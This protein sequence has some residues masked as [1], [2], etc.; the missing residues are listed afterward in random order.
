MYLNII[1]FLLPFINYLSFQATMN[2]TQ[3]HSNDV[4]ALKVIY[5]SM[6]LVCKVFF[7]LNY[8][9][10][11][12]FFEDNMGTWMSN[13]HT[14]LTVEVKS[15]ESSVSRFYNFIFINHFILLLTIGIQLTI[16][17]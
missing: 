6:V 5:S 8:Q 7:S 4:N 11:P 13:F 10:L 2:L 17:I 12:E 3:T 16:V 1:Y 15:L 14:M 9:D